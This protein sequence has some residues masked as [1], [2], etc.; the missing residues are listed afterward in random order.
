MDTT[1]D[2]MRLVGAFI[3]DGMEAKRSNDV[4]MWAMLGAQAWLERRQ[5][6]LQR[7]CARVGV[8]RTHYGQNLVAAESLTAAAGAWQWSRPR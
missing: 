2:R 8:G 4:P 7:G 1:V 3:G 6:G 5:P